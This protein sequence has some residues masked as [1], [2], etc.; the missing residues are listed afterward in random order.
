MSARVF[1]SSK[2]NAFSFDDRL[3]VLDAPAKVGRTHKDDKSDSG[4]AFFDCKVLSRA[5]AIIDYEDGK[6]FFMD[7]GSSNGS[8]VNNI[9][10]SK[11]GEESKPTQIYNGDLLRFGS[12]VV[13]KSKNV[14]QK[15]IVAR[16]KLFHPDGVEC[17]VRPPNSALYRPD[18]TSGEDVILAREGLESSLSRDSTSRQG[19]E[20]EQI[21]GEKLELSTRLGVIEIMLEDRERFCNSVL[22]K[23]SEDQNEIAKLRQMIDN[24]NLDLGNLEQAL[25]ETQQEL[26]R[27][28]SSEDDKTISLRME[29]NQ[30]LKEREEIFNEERLALKKQFQEVTSN[31]IS[32]LNRIKSL[33]AEKGYAMAE[34]EKVTVKEADQ[35]EYKQELEYSLECLTTELEHTKMLLEEAETK[36][37]VQRSDEDIK[38]LQKDE[39]SIKKLKEEVAYIKKELIDSRSR[40]AAAEDELNTVKGTVETMVNNT[41]SLTNEIELMNLAKKELTE[42]YDETAAKADHLETLLATIESQ[43]D[44]DSKSKVEIADLKAELAT[45]QAEVKVKMQEILSLRDSVRM[46]KE[47]VGQ[48]DIEIARQEGQ[49]QF[50]QEEIELMKS[51]GGDVEGL[52]SETNQLRNKLGHVVSELEVTRS[53]N[54]A[55]SSELQTQ[56]LLYQELKKMRGVGEE[57]ELLQQASKDVL[58]ARDQAEDWHRKWEQAESERAR[59]VDEKVRLMRENAQLRSSQVTNEN[60]VTELENDI[61]KK[62]SSYLAPSDAVMSNV[63]SLKLYEILLGLLFISIIISWNPFTLPL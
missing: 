42:K 53:D 21:R 27:A 62:K 61:T 45:S 29:S 25:G 30:L 3:L 56:H 4:N 36:K 37:V 1:L 19:F 46:E 43:P 52:Q 50:L 60:G 14:T 35:F 58:T 57:V 13:D 28:Q 51:Q 2:Q 59:M 44:V 31:E 54:E 23:Q 26:D 15:C 41:N 10:L 6:F 39:E 12:D 55:L 8:F 63:G 20:L 40:K 38:H 16:V 18:L 9:R 24:Q 49:V 32:L 17:D 11:T 33:E 22:A 34:V 47:V 7:T 5:H 48:K